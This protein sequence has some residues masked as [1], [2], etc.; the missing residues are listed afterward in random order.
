MQ[1]REL[2]EL[3]SELLDKWRDIRDSSEDLTEQN[4]ADEVIDD[5]KGVSRCL[6]TN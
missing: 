2:K 5:L 6:V 1:H 4:L 3:I